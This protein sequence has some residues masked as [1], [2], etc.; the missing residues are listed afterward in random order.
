MSRILRLQA[1]TTTSYA[2]DAAA[3]DSSVSAGLCS[4]ISGGL[5]SSVS[6]GLCAADASAQ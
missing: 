4:S 6:A 2:K 1:L 5:C 3:D